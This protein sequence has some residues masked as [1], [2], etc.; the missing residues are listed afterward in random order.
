MLTAPNAER[1]P[2][3]FPR[4]SGQRI[5]K[6]R[7]AARLRF[8]PAASLQKHFLYNFLFCAPLIFFQ[9]RKR[10]CFYSLVL[11]SRIQAGGGAFPLGHDGIP[12]PHP[13]LPS[14]PRLKEVCGGENINFYFVHN[15]RI[16]YNG[17]N[18]ICN[19]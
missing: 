17:N 1:N 7:P 9:L 18:N 12:P 3:F 16:C 6:Y 4:E 8:A 11:P 10:K 2:N 13:L 15:R 19:L 14:R 5:L